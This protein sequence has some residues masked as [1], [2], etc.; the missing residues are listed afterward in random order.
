MVDEKPIPTALHRAYNGL[1]EQLKAGL[2][3]SGSI[4]DHPVAKGDGTEANWLNMLK[5]HLPHRYQAETAFIIDADGQQSEQ[6]DIVLYDRQYTPELYNVSGQRIIPA[7]GVYAA[8]EI[9][10]VLDRRNIEYAAGKIA[11]VRRLK[12]SSAS[13]VHAGGEHAP[14]DALSPIIGGILTTSAGWTPP[15][16][17]AFTS[18]ISGLNSE[19]LVDLGCAATSGAFETL[20]DGKDRS[21][22]TCNDTV[23]LAFFFLRLL[24]RLQRVGTVP[25]IEYDRYLEAFNTTT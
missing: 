1:Q 18:C 8:L 19:S 25:A 7:E 22:E 3:S 10:P 5:S 11:S 14:R 15:F 21:I 12:R 16:G 4:I 20:V 2:Q 13:I 9:K 24:R 6:I 17:T 23:A